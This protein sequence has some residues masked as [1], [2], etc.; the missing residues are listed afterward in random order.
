MTTIDPTIQSTEGAYQ[1][2]DIITLDGSTEFHPLIESATS[3][4][5]EKQPSSKFVELPT[6]PDKFSFLKS[7][8]KTKPTNVVK[9]N[10]AFVSKIVANEQ[11]AKIISQKNEAFYLFFNSGRAI[12]WVD[13]MWKLQAPLSVLYLKEAFV[14]CHDVNLVTRDTM[15]SVV[16]H[17]TGDIL[18]FWPISGKY[19]RLNR[20]GIIHKCAVTYIKWIPGSENM[21][22]AGFDDGSMMVFDK[23]MEDQNYPIPA[24]NEEYLIRQAPKGSKS[25]PRVYWKIS[26]KS[27]TCIAFSPDMVHFAVTSMD[28][29]LRIFNLQTEKLLDVYKSF[30]GGFTCATWSPDGRFVVAGSQDDLISIYAFKGR[31]LAR[32]QGHSS[33]P[34]A[35]AFDEWKCTDKHFRFASAGEDTRILFWDFSNSMFQRKQV[36]RSKSYT[37]IVRND[38]VNYHTTPPKSAIPTIE[39]VA[40][41][42]IGSVPLSSI[43]FRE[44]GIV[45]ADKLGAV[46]AWTR[47]TSQ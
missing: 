16:G 14:T 45:L 6:E 21:F 9:T 43:F 12:V 15:N 29:T 4:S 11:I 17:T 8:N 24:C 32:C 36:S 3:P 31:L 20:G 27:I 44:D 26:K 39:P 30:F 5:V 18:C 46:Y 38:E 25:N 34:T 7:K 2:R 41:K 37:E 13:Y 47:P 42:S 10:S 23:D 22:I 35:V 19:I 33:W 1:L 28:G 40:G